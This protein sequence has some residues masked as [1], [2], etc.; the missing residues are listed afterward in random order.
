MIYCRIHIR[1]QV[2]ECF[3]GVGTNDQ[4]LLCRVDMGV[5]FGEGVEGAVAFEDG[6]PGR[7]VKLRSGAIDELYAVEVGD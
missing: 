6:I 2:F 3:H 5:A 1:F 7:F 4:F